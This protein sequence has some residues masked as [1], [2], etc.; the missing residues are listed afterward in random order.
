MID[1]EREERQL[2]GVDKWFKNRCQGILDWATG[3]GKT[4]GAIMAIKRIE[5]QREPLYLIVVPSDALKKQ[6]TYSLTRQ[7]TKKTMSRILIETRQNLLISNLVYKVDVEII[8]E[9]HEYTTESARG[10]IDG[11]IVQAKA[12]LGL[13][14]STDDKDFKIILNYIPIVDVITEQEA[15]DKGFTAEFVE[16]NLPLSLSGDEQDMYKA[17]TDV[18]VKM[19]PRFNND[20]SL[21]QRCLNG[22]KDP[23]T[24]KHYAS[25]NWCIGVATKNGWREDLQPHLETH[26]MILDIWTPNKVLLY[27]VRLMTAV[28]DRKKLL[29][30]CKSKYEATL[31]ILNKFDKVKTI[32]F[33]ESTSFADKL[34]T[35]TKE[36]HKVVIYHSQLKTIIQPSEKTG[37]PIKIGVGTQKKQATEAIKSGK[38]RVILTSKALDRGFDVPDLR[39]GLT[40]SGTQNPTQYKQRGGRLKRKETENVFDDCTVLLI[41]LYVKDS[42]DEKWLKSRQ[43]KAVHHIFEAETIDDIEYT[44]PPNLEFIVDI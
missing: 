14:A 43:S 15:Q 5:K 31:Q 28:Q 29:Q 32:V 35:M 36:Q 16:Y 24:K 3:V 10:I 38:A 26:A 27:A 34:Y 18:I 42:Q 25:V 11:S 20:L 22:G 44:P 17:Y 1:K 23:K 30:T 37:K 40:T 33:S 4:Y 13:T 21:A 2:Q 7:L 6:W 8:D 41:N 9:I 19:L 12:Q 39:V